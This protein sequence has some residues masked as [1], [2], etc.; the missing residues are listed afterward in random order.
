M[1]L[2]PLGRLNAAAG[3]NEERIRVLGPGVP[4]YPVDS[5]REEMAILQFRVS[6]QAKSTL[7]DY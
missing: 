6:P 4:K 1:F 7:T 5:L 2:E 3:G